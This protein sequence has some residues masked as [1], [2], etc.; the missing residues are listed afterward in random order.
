MAVALSIAGSDPTGGAGLQ[1]DLQ[2]FH[3]L[4]V[5]GAGVPTALTVQDTRAVHRVLPLF[6]S[7]VLDQLRVVMRDLDVAAVKVGMLATDDVARSVLLALD[8]LP[9]G[10]PLVVDPVLRAS[11]GASLLERRAWA[12]LCEFFPRATLVTP[13]LPELE[14]LAGKKTSERG[15]IEDA[16]RHMLVGLGARAVLVKGGHREADTDDLLARR[17]PEGGVRLD[18]LS[19]ERIPG[20]PVHGTGCA[21]SSA[22][23]AELALG[24]ELVDAVTRAR[25]FVRA[26][27]A[28]AQVVGQ[29]AR[30]LGLP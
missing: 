15:A 11:S 1:L 29:G 30:L 14:S 23:A 27:I 8:E 3:A 26:A 6:P 20:D 7:V 24:A 18:W 5:H 16:A 4:G 28:S 21:L 17:D 9:S 12:T 2:V 19:S 10:T 13:N 25:A 22:V